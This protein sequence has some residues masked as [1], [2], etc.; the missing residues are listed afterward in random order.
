MANSL[1]LVEYAKGLDVKDVRRPIIEMFAASTDIFAALPF[2]GLTG[3]VFE[4]YRTAQLPSPTF[5]AINEASSNGGGKI[6]P[7]QEASY[8]MDHDI[9]IDR[10]IVDRTAWS[11]AIRRSRWALPQPAANGSTPSSG[12]QHHPAPR[13]QRARQA[14]GTVQPHD[15]ELAASGGAALSLLKLDT[16]INAVNKPTHIIAPFDSKPLWIQAARTSTL[17]GF[18]IQTWDQVGGPSSPMPACR[19]CSATKRTTT[20]PVLQFNEVA[21]GGGGAVTASLYVVLVRPRQVA[22]HSAEAARTP[23]HR[24]AR[25]RHH[26]PHA[27][28]V[29]RG[30][31]RRAQV[32]L[33]ASARLDQRGDRR[34]T[35]SV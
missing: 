25:K 29:G 1:T 14:L 21:T 15:L 12:R 32:L 30:S 27:S 16:A 4:G 19:S 6:T 35:H 31:R 20:Y 18:V 7:F 8:V 5:R 9:D 34:L 10:A 23:R 3:P 28:V 26:L 2:E 11:A 24:P 17:T 33:L 22:R 13:I